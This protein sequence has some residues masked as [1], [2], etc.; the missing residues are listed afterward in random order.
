MNFKKLISTVNDA[1]QEFDFKAAGKTVVDTAKTTGSVLSQKG[2]EIQTH[3]KDLKA[4]NKDKPQNVK[5]ER[6][7]DKE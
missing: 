4:A 6:M 2:K 7:P 1:V 5:V 3:Y